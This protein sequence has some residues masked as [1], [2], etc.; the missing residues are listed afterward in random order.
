MAKRQ[1]TNS[2][3]EV[4]QTEATEEES[5]ES[6]S[7]EQQAD[8]DAHIADT[9]EKSKVAQS[10]DTQPLST[11]AQIME[12][13]SRPIPQRLLKDVQKG[14]GRKIT[15][16]SHVV[17]TKYLNAYCS[18]WQLRIDGIVDLGDSVAVYGALGIPTSDQGIVWRSEIGRA[19]V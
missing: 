1:S 6:L 18:G 11:L 9:P 8:L 17:T 2:E 3:P 12:I 15:T 10:K 4:K 16:F 5:S 7:P 14:G 13:L 19:H